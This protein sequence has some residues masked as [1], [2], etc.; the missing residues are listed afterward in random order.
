[1]Q[2]SKNLTIVVALILLHLSSIFAQPVLKLADAQKF[3]EEKNPSIIKARFNLAKA[4][5]DYLAAKS[6]FLPS[7]ST[8][9]HWSHYDHDI[10]SFARDEVVRSRENY[11][12][13]LSA[14]YSLFSGGK[15]YISL[16]QSK[17]SVDI[18]QKSYE[19]AKSQALLSLTNSY[20]S[21]LEAQTNISIS[22]D[23]LTR[24]QDE[25]KIILQKRS[26]GSASDVDVAKI[27]VTVAENKLDVIRSEN[28]FA[29]ARE[30]L[31]YI[32]G[33]P[34]DTVFA[35]DSS[36]T[37][38]VLEE[39]PPLARFLNDVSRNHSVQ[40]A[41]ISKQIASLSKL[42]SYLNYV[43]RVSMSGSW[44]WSGSQTPDGFS[45]ISDEGSASFGLSLSWDIFDGTS[46]IAAIKKSKISYEQS[47]FDLNDTDESVRMQIR[48]AHRA[49]R[50]AS[51]SYEL[52][53][54]Q[55]EQT[56]LLLNATKKRYE[57]GSSTLL[58]LLDAELV[59]KRA[60]ST[61]IS[62]IS[63]FFVQQAKLQALIAQ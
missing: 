31:C 49:M 42:S 38:A 6:L 61:R 47:V 51:A 5:A 52:A 33:L 16:R 36:M 54:A 10:I 12:L 37:P 29:T 43:P 25:E 32:L 22:N 8:S 50:Q 20:F 62:A 28:T 57:L 59:F 41:E 46:R 15:D 17:L 45:Q 60:Q 53:V 35:L 34:L 1:M 13:G 18:A 30:N 11:S 14:G 7:L 63:Q 23:A 26:L 44:G 56:R 40:T 19:E 48:D 55:I 39:I 3:V 58:E 9:A 27:T 24:T 2:Y 21:A 4:E